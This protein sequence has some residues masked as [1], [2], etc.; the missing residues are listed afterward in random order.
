MLLLQRTSIFTLIVLA[1]SCATV[2]RESIAGDW[3]GELETPLGNLPVVFHFYE[4]EEGFDCTMDGA[5]ERSVNIPCSE[6]AKDGDAVLV[7]LP[8][9]GA[10]YEAT[11]EEDGMSGQWTQAGLNFDLNL[12]RRD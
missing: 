4:T 12:A 6:V 5:A 7:E 1:S 2:E 9:V 11:L 10:R 3:N 8:M